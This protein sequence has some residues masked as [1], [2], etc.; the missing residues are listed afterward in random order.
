MDSPASDFPEVNIPPAVAD[1]FRQGQPVQASN[2]PAQGLVR[3]S[4]GE[5]RKFIGMAEIA[6]DGRLAPR[7]LVVEYQD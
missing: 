6:D 1:F 5:A 2:A 4:E 3:V 7:R